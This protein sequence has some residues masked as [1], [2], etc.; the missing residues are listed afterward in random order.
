MVIM[1]L[2]GRVAVAGVS[3]LE[4]SS[5]IELFNHCNWAH[6]LEMWGLQKRHH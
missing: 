5:I 6:S 2:V 3:V 1:V 4:A